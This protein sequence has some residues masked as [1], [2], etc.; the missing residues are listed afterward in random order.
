MTT[1]PVTKTKLSMKA[2]ISAAAILMLA[3][4]HTESTS[5][6]NPDR[7]VQSFTCAAS[8]GWTENDPGSVYYS[9][10]FHY[11]KVERSIHGLS[12]KEAIRFRR[13]IGVSDSWSVHCYVDNGVNVN[14]LGSFLDREE[15]I[16]SDLLYGEYI[17]RGGKKIF[18]KFYFVRDWEP[19]YLQQSKTEKPHNQ[20]G[21]QL[22][23]VL[24]DMFSRQALD[25]I[26]PWMERNNIVP[27]GDTDTTLALMV[28][29]ALT[30]Q[31][32]KPGAPDGKIGPNTVA[33]IVAWQLAFGLLVG[34]DLS[35]VIAAIVHVALVRA[36]Y[37]PGPVE[38][39]FGPSAI[40]AAQAWAPSYEKAARDRNDRLS[41]PTSWRTVP[42][43]KDCVSF[44][45]SGGA[46][47]YRFIRNTCDF[48][49]DVHWCYTDRPGDND[50]CAPGR[51]GIG[52]MDRV[53]HRATRR[54]AG[55]D[56]YVGS[57]G[58]RAR[59]AS[60]KP[61]RRGPIRYIACG[62]R[63]LRNAQQYVT[64]WDAHTAKFRCL[65]YAPEQDDRTPAEG[66]AE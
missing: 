2:V 58:L 54:G 29:I 6:E 51:A 22:R 8:G 25:A 35:D 44:V 56:Y 53:G 16:R 49:I 14:E 28:Q 36:G 52:Y 23:E 60:R 4:I 11:T 61:L 12:Q 15:L 62:H 9:R 33:A 13:H 48:K 17:V 45:R 46:G 65:A 7:L 31:D 40:E 41:P 55:P 34:A 43:A 21:R 19:R 37:D 5:A 1:V 27:T 50:Y 39:M 32:F 20:A 24:A 59:E 18:R 47:N 26:V 30:L 63:P 57:D 10:K 3:A 64:E 38:E 42:H 66:T